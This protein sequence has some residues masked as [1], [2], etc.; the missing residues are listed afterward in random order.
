MCNALAF[1]VTSS[2]MQIQPCFAEAQI[3]YIRRWIWVAETDATIIST[4]VSSLVASAFAWWLVEW[5]TARHERARDIHSRIETL[6]GMTMQYP[7]VEFESTC[8]KWPNADL[9]EEDRVRYENYC[10]FVFNLIGAVWNH[11]KRSPQCARNMLH[12][13]E[14]IW[15]HRVWWNADPE[16]AKAYECEFNKFVK[17]VIEAQ[18]REGKKGCVNVEKSNSN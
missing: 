4:A 8:S 9:S 16:N 2:D 14:L 15:K 10:C 5:V 3:D 18:E 12:I 11:C 17:Q 6:I 1:E 7:V 13:D